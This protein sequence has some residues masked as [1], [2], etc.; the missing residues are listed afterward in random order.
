MANP[1]T[2]RDVKQVIREARPWIKTAAR[3]GYA[4]K[5]IVYVLIG[6][7]AMFV[8]LGRRGEPEDFSGV[9]IA[10]FH[11]PFGNILLA[12]LA[13][14]LAGYGLWCLIQAALDTEKKGD[15]FF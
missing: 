8:A 15:G 10:V 6:L 9:L 1:S 11:Q 2:G 13:V 14:G 5:G 4:A 12:L 7:A 3:L